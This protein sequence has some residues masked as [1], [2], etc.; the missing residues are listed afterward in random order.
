L[1]KLESF[2]VADLFSTWIPVLNYRQMLILLVIMEK[3]KNN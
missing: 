3:R 1:F 2:Y